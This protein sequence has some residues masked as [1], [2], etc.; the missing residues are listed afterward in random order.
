MPTDDA[1]PTPAAAP[2]QY[3]TLRVRPD[4]DEQQLTRSYSLSDLADERGYRISVKREGAASRYLHERVKVGDLLDVAAPRGNFVLRE[5]TR[6]VVLLSAGVGATPV[7][8]ML[9]AL[10]RDHSTRSVWWLHGARNHEEHAF[11]A[12]VDEL[13]AA[14]P[15]SHRLVAYSKPAEADAPERRPR[16]L[17]PAR[18]DASSSTRA[19]PRTPTTTCA[20]RTASCARSAPRSPP[21]ASLPERIATEVF[22]AVAI[23]SSGH[24]ERRRPRDLTSPT[25]HPAADRS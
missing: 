20:D 21:A 9:H 10:A 15:D 25:V 11:G 1:G 3:L 8:A 6:P 22:G 17:R 14:L 16:P 13:L 12:E 19:S 23:H 7:L 24:R 2:G 18:P 5:G 4:A